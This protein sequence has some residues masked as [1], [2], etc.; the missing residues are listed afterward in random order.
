MKCPRKKKEK[1]IA[2]HLLD[3]ESEAA[4]EGEVPAV[5]LVFLNLESTL[6]NLLSLLATDG[7]G[8]GDLLVTTDAEGAHSVPCLGVDGGLSR[9]LLEH[10]GGTSE[11]VTALTDANVQAELLNAEGAHDVLAPV[12]GGLLGGRGGSGGSGGLSVSLYS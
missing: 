5:E 3:T 9:Q 6:E 1:K 7:D 4:V 12:L 8:D 11:P 10:L 2:T